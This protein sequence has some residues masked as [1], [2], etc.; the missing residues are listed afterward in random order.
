MDPEYEAATPVR[1][2]SPLTDFRN[3]PAQEPAT[4]VQVVCT[5]TPAA[6][7]SGAS[8][9]SSGSSSEKRTRISLTFTTPMAKLRTGQHHTGQPSCSEA[10][11]AI[12]LSPLNT[13][14][15]AS[16]GTADPR[17]EIRET[18]VTPCNH[19]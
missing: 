1:V 8:S 13:V 7:G 14:R 6:G 19:W 11:C 9:R 4:P 2:Q 16:S 3:Q 5:V 17:G 18:F 15:G 10:A 12:C